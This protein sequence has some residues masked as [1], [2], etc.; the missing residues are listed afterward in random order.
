[1]HDLLVAAVHHTGAAGFADVGGHPSIK[2]TLVVADGATVLGEAGPASL[3]APA[4]K[5]SRPEPEIPG[6][7]TRRELLPKG[8][9]VFSHVGCSPN[10]VGEHSTKRDQGMSGGVIP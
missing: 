4:A 1:M 10:E 5:S 7:K 9:V 2:D 6:G 3:R 8:E